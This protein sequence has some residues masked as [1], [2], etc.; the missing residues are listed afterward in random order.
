MDYSTVWPDGTRE[1]WTDTGY[2]KTDPTGTVIEQRPLTV[3]ERSVFALRVDDDNRAA[4][5]SQARTAYTNNKAF[6]QIASPTQAQVVAQVAALT[7]QV[8]A[9]IRL[10][11]TDLLDGP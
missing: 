9:L 11:V 6:L 8:N 5:F 10:A 7:R 1:E 3:H 4:L 2:T